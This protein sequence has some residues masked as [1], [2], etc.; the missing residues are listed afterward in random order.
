MRATRAKEL[1]DRVVIEGGGRPEYRRR[2]KLYM[3]VRRSKG[4]TPVVKRERQR[5]A[6]RAK[7]PT[8]ESIF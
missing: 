7:P 5:R 8:T 1:K 6:L 4:V 2:K 3:E